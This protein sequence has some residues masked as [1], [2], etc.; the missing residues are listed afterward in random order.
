MKSLHFVGGTSKVKPLGLF[1]LFQYNLLILDGLCCAQ[2]M[3]Q[4]FW[5]VA[6]LGQFY[7]EVGFILKRR[8]DMLKMI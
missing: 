7:C 3:W 8:L 2:V 6:L 4:T 5:V 1:F